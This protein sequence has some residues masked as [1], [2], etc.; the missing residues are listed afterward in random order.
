MG[1]IDC[2]MSAIIQNNKKKRTSSFNTFNSTHQNVNETTT[3]GIVTFSVFYTT[4]T[5]KKI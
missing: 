3:K 4:Y 5:V 2:L 1:I